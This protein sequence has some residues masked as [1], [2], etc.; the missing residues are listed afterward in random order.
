MCKRN[1]M[2]DQTGKGRFRVSVWLLAAFVVALLGAGPLSS[3]AHAATHVT[4]ASDDGTEKCKDDLAKNIRKARESFFATILAAIT[5]MFK[6]TVKEQQKN[7]ILNGRGKIDEKYCISFKT[8]S[9]FE[10]IRDLLTNFVSAIKGLIKTY[11]QKL[12][13]FVCEFAAEAI[14]SVLSAICIPLPEIPFPNIDL[15]SL[16]G[17]SCN[18]LSL[19]SFIQVEAGTP[20]TLGGSM[21]SSSVFKYPVMRNYKRVTLF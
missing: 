9:F 19:S 17:K 1:E 5:E 10:F 12:L 20:L 15:P 11:I 18:G 13:N 21:P 7:P 6:V 16:T 14:N 4:E 3:S 2:K 8:G